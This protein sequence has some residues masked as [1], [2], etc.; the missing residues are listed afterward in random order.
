MEKTRENGKKKRKIMKAR[1]DPQKSYL[2]FYNHF[3]PE[4]YLNPCKKISYEKTALLF[5]PTTDM[6]RSTRVKKCHMHLKGPNDLY[7][8]HA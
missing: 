8:Y 4:A 5:P 2:D 1:E 6:I 7:S 3:K